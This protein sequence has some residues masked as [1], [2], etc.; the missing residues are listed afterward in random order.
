MNEALK[1]DT[2]TATPCLL[3]LSAPSGGGKT[4]LARALVAGRR[5]VGITVSHTT[6]PA[7]PG[8]EDGVHY[9][10]VNRETFEHMITSG[11][12]V[13]Y[14]TVYDNYYG[15]SRAAIDG[16]IQAGRHA[17]LDID[18]Q[19]ARIVR[20]KFPDA[21]SVFVMPPS[22]EALENRLRLRRQDSEETIARRMHEADNQMS[23]KDEFDVIIIN[24]DFERAL[25]QLGALLD[26]K[27]AGGFR[28]QFT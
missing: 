11:D 24:D 5:D 20:E 23:H 10:F 13:E 12:F 22:R 9:H 27:A 15:T 19:G 14:A 16:L 25:A 17:I 2:M 21:L 1:P 28:G 3:I 8:E 4:S 18:W 26:E 6:R 7:R